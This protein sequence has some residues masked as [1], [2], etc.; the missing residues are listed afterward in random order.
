MGKKSLELLKRYIIFTFGLTIMAFGVA[1]SIKAELGTSPIS[2]LPYVA[3][4]LTHLTVGNTTIIMHCAFIV[5]QI[6]ILRKEYKLIQLI[7]LPVAFVFGYLT[8]FA[9]WCISGITVSLYWQQWIICVIGIVLVAFGVSCEITA[10]VV[11]LAGEGVVLAVCHMTRMKFGY[12][13]VIF[14]IS[15]VAV[16]SALSFCFLHRLEGVR[17]GTLAAAMFVGLLAKRFSGS[18]TEKL[19]AAV[20]QS[21]QV[22]ENVSTEKPPFV[23]VINREFGSGGHEIGKRVAEILKLPFYDNE[24]VDAVAKETGLSYQY[25]EQREE[26][27]PTNLL[28]RLL[29]A[30]EREEDP[31]INEV[32][33]VDDMI[34][35]SESRT[36]KRLADQGPCVIV[37]RCAGY[38]LKS[39]PHLI[40]VFIYSEC[41]K[42]ERRAVEKYGVEADAASTEINR[43]DHKRGE[44]YR[45]YIGKEWGMRESY[46]LMINSSLLGINNSADI[47]AKATLDVFAVE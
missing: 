25:V 14:D 18:F 24:I 40:R 7:Q 41:D 8:D 19:C 38:L 47:I 20:I 27:K 11:T 1:F 39:F 28:Y 36:V 45:H 10:G 33:S 29:E 16:A 46:D 4:L 15:L 2:S 21:N 23:I 5:L 22:N 44:N 6:L 26:R 9:I 43:I 42:R 35:I 17:E 3:S 30:F 34:F 31:H 32:L 13:K 37:G 12:M